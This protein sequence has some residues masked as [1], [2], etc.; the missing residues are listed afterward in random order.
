MQV[1]PFLLFGK[2]VW[3]TR[4]VVALA[5]L[6]AV[7]WMTGILRDIF[8]NPY[9]WSV[10]FLLAAIPL[11]FLYTRTA[12]EYAYLA[13]FY[14]G[15]IYYYLLYREG[16]PKYLYAALVC[17]ALAFYSYSP[18]QIVMAVSGVLLFFSDLR[19]HLQNRRTAFTG[20]GV[21]A[22]LALPLVRFVAGNPGDYTQRLI[23][24]NSY[25]ETNLTTLG[26]I[27]RYLVNYLS[28]LNPFYWFFPNNHDLIRHRMAG[29]GFF[30]WLMLP[31]V[32]W[33]LYTLIRGFR[34][35]RNRVILA[36]L[37]AAPAGA[38][39]IDLTVHREISIILPL[40]VSALI[41]FNAAVAYFS[42]R[43]PLNPAIISYALV[44]S[45]SAGS[46]FMLVDALKNGK[47][48]FHDYGLDGLQWGASQ[49]FS[50]AEKY[51]IQHPDLTLAIS[52]NWTFQADKLMRFFLPNQRTVIIGTADRF[53]DN[54]DDTI[55]QFRFVLIPGD[56]QK[57]RE[58]GKFLEPV[59]EQ[60]ISFP[61]GNPGFYFVSLM[62]R[63]NA[64]ELF[65]QDAIKHAML[66]TGRAN[67]LG[68]DIPVYHTRLDMGPIETIF[69]GDLD[70]VTRTS[71]VNPFVVEFA[72]PAG[73]PL[74]GL[75][76]R[77]GSEEVKV[78]VTV[79]PADGS[80]PQIFTCEAGGSQG[81]KDVRVEFG[82]LIDAKKLKFEVLDVASAARS[83]VHIWEV[84]FL[85]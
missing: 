34:E 62:Y 83:F 53:M 64:G 73:H 14:S 22:L 25:L 8:R 67:I 51:S 24:Y 39:L 13:I 57:A 47:T 1:L 71:A 75:S 78:T 44:V 58:S 68:V 43:R 11:W 81:I 31:F 38:A 79:D 3:V 77:L 49:V 33:G 59:V 23:M 7:F 56:Y 18:G 48:W 28:G 17:G 41:G 55:N 63:D 60:V 85:E 20:L 45:L 12:F 40:A 65:R 36:G 46:L 16:Q 32:L 84:Q 80:S 26:K 54:Y 35:S 21:I 4:A 70:S 15:F 19:C 29:Y 69:D 74:R 6:L 66:E 2:S 42:R 30:P 27:S 61:D 50:A 76:F 9:W 5:S 72:V 10:P 52:P 82:K 37:L